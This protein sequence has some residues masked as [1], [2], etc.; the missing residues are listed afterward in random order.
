M[1]KKKYSRNVLSFKEENDRIVASSKHVTLSSIIKMTGM[2]Y[3][4]VTTV[5][6]LNGIF[7]LTPDIP[8]D[9]YVSH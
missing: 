1:E 2:S 5:L 4:R 6:K 9:E 3:K 7:H 8:A